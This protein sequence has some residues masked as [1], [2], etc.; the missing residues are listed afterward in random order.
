M[1]LSSYWWDIK[2]DLTPPEPSLGS[3]ETLPKSADL[4]VIGGGFTGLSAALTA[5][6]H[7]RSVV[8]LDAGQPGFGAST[9]NGGICSGHIRIPHAG[10][11]SK[12]G[13][14]FADNV[15]GEGI[16]ARADLVKF[17]EDEKIDCQINQA[18]HF[19][20]AMSV[21]AYD[22][23]AAQADALNAI[24]G[25]DVEVIPRDQQHKEIAT[26]RFFGG[27]LRRE[28]GGYHPGKFFAGLIRVVLREGVTLLSE[29]P[30][31]AIE[32]DHSAAAAG[33]KIITTPRGMI[34]AGT[35]IVATNGYNH[36]ERSFGHFVRK[37]IVPVQSC[38][39]VTENLGKAQVKSLMPGLRMYGNTDKVSAY[40]RPVPDQDRILLGAR[41]F[42][43][44]TPG[45]RT[46]SFLRNKLVGMLPQL[47]DVKIDYCWLGN[48]AFNRRLLPGMFADNGI[49]YA[50]GYAGSGTVWA[51]WLGKKTAEMALGIAGG[52]NGT[53]PS[54]F[55]NKPPA[56]I[57]LYD[58]NPWFM[59]FIVS[60]FAAQDKI[61]DWTDR[62]K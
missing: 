55:Y 43:R 44:D 3:G 11:A 48:V 33:A 50:C 45:P 32:D 6:R 28:I 47:S 41:S 19:N 10:L 27:L 61:N 42:D 21:R 36:K 20:G 23:M 14:N 29:T 22:Q 15:Y 5:A 60:F 30:A 59:P 31:Q 37:R 58:G 1:K 46:V 25:H 35:V 40:F 26:D 24:P 34:K 53:S 2:E 49:Y 57:P 38:I 9:R 7:G 62:S 13:R 8:V 56:P 17:C 51:R 16:E 54:V 12:F 52:P 4:V 39:I 18:G